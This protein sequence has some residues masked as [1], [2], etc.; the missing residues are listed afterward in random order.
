MRAT[1]LYHDQALELEL[2]DEHLVAAWSGPAGHSRGEMAGLIREALESPRDF[3]PLRQSVVPGDHVTIA[4]DPSIPDGSLVLQAIAETL[5]EAGVE[6]GGITVLLPGGGSRELE[7][8]LP[9]GTSLLVHDPGDRAGQAYLA[10]TKQGRRIYL[11]RHLTDA[12]VVVP[13][14]RIGFDPILGYHG[15]WSMLF[16]GLTDATSIQDH[17]GRLR[18]DDDTRHAS[19]AQANREEALEVSWLLGTLF[20]VGVVAG[21]SGICELAAGRDRSVCEQGIA[22]LD[23]HWTFRPPSR[24]EVVVAGVGSGAQARPHRLK[25]WLK[26]WRRRGGWFSMGARSSCSRKPTVRWARR[27]GT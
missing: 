14:G 23:Q 25:R 9:P 7:T 3:P 5:H 26:A 2:P 24:A 18:A 12:D 22:W 13:V 4:M 16:P 11:S 27:F 17:K 1:V 8:T 15:P 6:P 20:H 10:T 19:S 21:E